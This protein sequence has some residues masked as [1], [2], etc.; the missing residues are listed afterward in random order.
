MKR[1]VL[2]ALLTSLAML[3]CRRSVP[4]PAGAIFPDEWDDISASMPRCLATPQHAPGY[5]EHRPFAL[6]SPSGVLELPADFRETTGRQRSKRTWVAADSS[7]FEYGVTPEPQSDLASESYGLKI[8]LEGPCSLPVA[9][10][11]ALAMRLR[12]DDTTSG[13]SLYAAD[14]TV[15]V[16]SGMAISVWIESP[17]A[18][19]R[20]QLLRAFSR[21]DLHG[22][23]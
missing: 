13:V 11:L 7:R 18:L 19:R 4:D 2:A 15:V 22:V 21:L 23:R 5:D 3:A 14:A 6:S 20:E 9:G 17:S 12:L 8:V 1:I 10:H 16:Q